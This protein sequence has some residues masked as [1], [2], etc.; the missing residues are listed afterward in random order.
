[1]GFI[2]DR[3]GIQ[4]RANSMVDMAGLLLPGG[5]GAMGTAGMAVTK[6]TVATIP[7]I[8][9]AWDFAA[10]SVAQLTMGVWRGEGVIP[11]R[12]LTTNQSRL[13]AGV[14]NPRQSWFLLWYIAEMSLEARSNGYLWK[15][16]GPGSQV[17]ALT[18]LHPDQVWPSPAE[19]GDLRY[20]VTFDGSVPQPPEVR[21]YGQITVGAETI[22]HIRGAGTIGE[23]I[24]P[25]PI[26][27]FR[28][29][30]GTALAKQNYEANLYENGV[31][32]GLGVAFPKEVTRKQAK[33]WRE[34]FDTENA[35][36]FNA[37]RTKVIGGG[38]AFS[39]IGMTQK[40]AQFVEAGLM[41][42]QDI[43]N[44]TGVPGWVLS[45]EKAEKSPSP[46]DEEA[47]W[48]H[49]GREVRLRRI[50][51]AL[52]ADPD[53]F[54]PGARDYPAFDTAE[55][56]HP[57]SRTADEIAH[58]QIQDGRLLVDEWRIPRG[59]GPLPDGLGMIPQVT[60]VGGAPNQTPKPS[61]S[62]TNGGA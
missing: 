55:S 51:S 48:V 27:R 54:G 9:R 30:L 29:S 13:F 15:T 49:G 5:R 25:T 2:G 14:P 24:A 52:A 7:A 4:R 23:L 39:Q 38:A 22:I 57:D 44:I 6:R 46:E 18:G 60:P 3:V 43:M 11:E 1:M 45:I 32:G 17:I 16:K 47:R 8:Y 58:A 26:E 12:V 34:V 37:G 19:N 10:S 56:I 36:S 31:L 53:I 42:L 62:S 28:T 61:P 50:E 33:E 35:G 40:D 20:D 59:M 21:G 41:T